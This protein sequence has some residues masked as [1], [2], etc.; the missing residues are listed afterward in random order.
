MAYITGIGGVFFNIKGDSNVLLEW[1]RHNLGLNVTE[2]GIE[3]P[4]K[5]K[6]L[7]TFRRNDTNSYINFTVD[8]I[9]AFM[10][11]LKSKNV[12]I[13]SEIKKYEY[14]SFAQIKD[15]AGNIIELFEVNKEAYYRMIEAEKKAYLEKLKYNEKRKPKKI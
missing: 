6:I 15:I 1:Y 4:I 8:N 13:V 9:E 10:K 11:E 14:G 7:I 2:Y 5:E 3:A 12:E